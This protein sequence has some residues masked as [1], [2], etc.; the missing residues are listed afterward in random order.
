MFLKLLSLLLF[1]LVVSANC[2]N[3]IYQ[4]TPMVDRYDVYNPEMTASEAMRNY[5]GIGS[6]VLGAS[7]KSVTSWRS[8]DSLAV[9]GGKLIK[10]KYGTNAWHYAFVVDSSND[11]QM[12]L[13]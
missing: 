4:D 10:F 7:S 8:G 11:T 2:G 1:G 5:P 9:S 13:K 12:K 3:Y 6:F